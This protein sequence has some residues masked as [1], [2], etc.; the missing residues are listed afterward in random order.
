MID[1]SAR[2]SARSYL[3]NSNITYRI[4]IDDL[5]KLIEVENPPKE[6]IELLQNR[7]GKIASKHAISV[8]LI[9]VIYEALKAIKICSFLPI[10][11]SPFSIVSMNCIKTNLVYKS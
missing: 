2:E 7:K 4:L 8:F 10:S 5:Q 6:E 11:I 3:Q 9:F 1:K